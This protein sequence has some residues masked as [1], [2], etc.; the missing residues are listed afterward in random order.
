LKHTGSIVTWIAI[1]VTGFLVGVIFSAWKLD[2]ETQKAQKPRGHPGSTSNERESVEKRIAAIKRMLEK[3]PDNF[4]AWA[5]LGNA[6]FGLEQY[7]EAAK[8][9]EKALELKPQDVDVMTDLGVSFRRL[10][11]GEEAA[12]RFKRVLEIDPDHELALFNL[13]IVLRDDLKDKKAAIQAWKDFLEKH[14]QSRLVIM[15][16]RWMKEAGTSPTNS[17]N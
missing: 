2:I 6:H 12:T 3:A 16:K 8:A 13:G 9:Y 17:D 14:P 5:Q 15:V 11:K 7:Q 4:R 10:G 1:F